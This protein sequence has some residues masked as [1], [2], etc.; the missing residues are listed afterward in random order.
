MFNI[1]IR[2]SEIPHSFAI[3][4]PKTRTPQGGHMISIIL[5]KTLEAA[6]V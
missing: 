3:P 5:K 2:G 6:Q 1:Y 4:P